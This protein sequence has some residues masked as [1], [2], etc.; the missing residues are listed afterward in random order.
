MTTAFIGHVLTGT[1]AARPSAS[2]VPQGTLY[3]CSTHGLIYQSDGVSVWTDPWFSPTIG[4]TPSTSFGSNSNQVGTANAG[5]ASS[6]NSRADHVHRG[7]ASLAHASNT[8]YGDVIFTTPGNSIGITVPTPGTLA[9]TTLDNAFGSNSNQVSTFNAPGAGSNTS[10]ADHI[11]RGVSSV[12]HSSNTFYGDVTLAA[13]TGVGITSPSSGTLTFHSTGGG[14]GGAGSAELLAY[15]AH[16]A[17]DET[18]TSTS[19][20]DLD[21]TNAIVTFTTPASG[22]VLVRLSATVSPGTTSGAFCSWGLRESTTDIAGAAGDSIAARGVGTTDQYVGATKVFV[23]TGISAGS[24]S[25]KWSWAVSAGTATLKAN[26]NSPAVMEVWA[27][28]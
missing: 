22:N 20:A 21:A 17:G 26:A 16:S 25:Y 5:G 24:H 7:V 1:H 23:L 8:L 12:S 14:S 27:L 11:H 10:R 13:G 18:T 6:S 19:L 28:S 2:A 4:G 9:F 15:K 3:A